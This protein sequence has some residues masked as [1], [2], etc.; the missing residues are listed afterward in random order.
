LNDLWIPEAAIATN[1]EESTLYRGVS[2]P[3]EQ[4]HAHTTTNRP[5]IYYTPSAPS[6]IE[7]KMLVTK[8]SL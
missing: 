8:D 6:G 3:P 5:G 2:S 1:D 7:S 4:S